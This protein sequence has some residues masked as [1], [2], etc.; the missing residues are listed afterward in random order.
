MGIVQSAPSLQR[1][2]LP[3]E[4]KEDAWRSRG[5]SI[6]VTRGFKSC[7]SPDGMGSRARRCHATESTH[8]RHKLD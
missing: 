7:V 5:D 3:R 2:D 4:R 1:S 8:R 6:F